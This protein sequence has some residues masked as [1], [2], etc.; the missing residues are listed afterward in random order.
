MFRF[1]RKTKKQRFNLF[2]DYHT[3]YFMDD[4]VQPEIPSKVTDE[5]V[6]RRI[7]VAPHIVVVYSERSATVPV[8]FEVH[9]A[10][11]VHDLS[12][13]DHVTECSIDVPSGRLAIL[14]CT[15]YLPDAA[16][17]RLQ[18]GCYRVRVLHAGLG[19]LSE[20]GLDGDD[21]Y[22]VVLWPGSP[23]NVRVLKQTTYE[24]RG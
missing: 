21:R 15:D 13:W 7:K 19:T 14:G 10:E 2:A 23:Q 17:I 16:R 3:F 22:R 11:P 8:E 20:T 18:P 9:D 12:E 6:R 4:D 24:V 5:D 1:L